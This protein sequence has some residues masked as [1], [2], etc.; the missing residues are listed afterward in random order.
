MKV[1]QN[2]DHGEAFSV[3]ANERSRQDPNKTKSRDFGVRMV[4]VKM[5]SEDGV[6]VMVLTEMRSTIEYYVRG[7]RRNLEE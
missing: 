6:L 2:D 5:Y 4:G 3:S 7:T 1:K